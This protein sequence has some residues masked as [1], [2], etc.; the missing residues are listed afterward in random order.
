MTLRTMITGREKEVSVGSR[1]GSIANKHNQYCGVSRADVSETD[2]SEGMRNLQGER[3]AADERSCNSKH[4]LT[5]AV[6]CENKN[7]GKDKR[8]HRYKT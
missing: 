7:G 1:V 8:E 2:M 6:G 4:L 3:N 5:F